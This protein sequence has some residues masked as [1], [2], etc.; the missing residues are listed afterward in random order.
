[1]TIRRAAAG[2]ALSLGLAL[3]GATAYAADPIKIGF[4]APLTGNVAN[5]GER[6][7]ESVQ[8]Y[9]DQV[10]AAGGIDGRKLEVVF[11]DDRNSPKEAASIAQKFANTPG[12]VAV[13]GSFSTTASLAAA[14]ILTEAKIPQISPSSSHPDWPKFSPYTFRQN[15]RQ[16]QLAPLHAEIVLDKLKGK[17]IAIPYFQDDWGLV[18]ANTTKAAIEKRGGEVVL[19]EPIAPNSRDFRPLVS[20]IK[21]LNPDVIFLPVHYQEASAFVQQLRQA[22]VTTPIGAPDPLSNPKF[23]ELAG[24][25]AEGVLL[26]T[27]FFADNPKVKSYVDAYKAKYNRLPDQYSALAYDSVA[28]AVNGVKAMLKSGKPLTGENVRDAIATAP[29]YEGLTGVTKYDENR[30]VEKK[31]TFIVIKSGAY[32]LY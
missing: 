31:S 7:R 18:T 15:V 28:V 4:F 1:M 23:L 29:A 11:E 13:I 3:T 21:S 25:D 12:L 10:N 20:K 14:P 5:F 26:Y 2:V 24:K 17:R 9:E 6:F 27:M 8:L 32:V 16:D 22:G 30:E 19:V